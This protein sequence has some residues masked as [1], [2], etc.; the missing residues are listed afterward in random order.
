MGCSYGPLSVVMDFDAFKERCDA[1]LGR[2]AGAC[3]DSGRDPADV[4]LLPVTKN[5][6]A[7][8]VEWAVR[9][10]FAAVAENRVQEAAEKQ[11]LVD[12]PLV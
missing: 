4:L 2:I 8:A 12:G 9:A 5:H 11:P 10:G 3:R 1:V 6:P 7:E